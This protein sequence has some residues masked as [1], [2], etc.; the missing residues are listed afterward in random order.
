MNKLHTRLLKLTLTALVLAGATVT[1]AARCETPTDQARSILDE[2][3]ATLGHL[4]ATNASRSDIEKATRDLEERAAPVLEAMT[5]DERAAFELEVE[6]RVAGQLWGM[7]PH[8]AS[9]NLF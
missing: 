3:V 4:Y 9:A 7:Q 1:A 5:D 6:T 2:E 8:A